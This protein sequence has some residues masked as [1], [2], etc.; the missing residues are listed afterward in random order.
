MADNKDNAPA[1]PTTPKVRHTDIPITT[2]IANPLAD[3]APAPSLTNALKAVKVED[4]RT[5]HQKPCAREAFMAGIGAGF[6]FGGIKLILRSSVPKATNWAVGMF[7]ATSLI[8]HEACQYRRMKELQGVAKAVEII[9][10][11]KAEKEALYAEKKAKF[12]AMKAEKAKQAE[13]EAKKGDKS[14][15][16]LW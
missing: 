9:D 1:T 11:K 5:V 8:A 3:N 12:L 14:S 2:D 10:K 6:A 7:I 13:E 16:K 4:F 15:W